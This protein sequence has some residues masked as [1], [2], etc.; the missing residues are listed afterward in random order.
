[1]QHSVRRM[2]AKAPTVADRLRA[3]RAARGVS[4]S[5]LAKAL[6]LSRGAVGQWEMDVTQ[7]NMKNLRAAAVILGV[8]VDWLASGRGNGPGAGGAPPTYQQTEPR[9]GGALASESDVEAWV[10]PGSFIRE[11]VRAPATRL[12]TIEAPAGDVGGR[13]TIEVTIVGRV[14]SSRTP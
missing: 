6:K 9:Q 2:M 8:D 14:R 7:P 4:Q 3:A 13:V 10:F 5:G 11:A 12:V 1:M